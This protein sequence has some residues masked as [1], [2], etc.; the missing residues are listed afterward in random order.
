MEKVLGFFLDLVG[1]IIIIYLV[2]TIFFNR[3][4]KVYKSLKKNYEIKLF[5]AKYDL[6]MRKT[7][8]KKV[9]RAVTIINSFILAFT[10]SLVIRING[11]MMSLIVGFVT[12]MI[13]IYSLYEITGNYFK[14][15]E[16]DKNV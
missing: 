9:L 6:Y 11:F 2:Y 16:D 4:R 10:T 12:I 1:I 5:I 3:K 14:R 8:Y 15:K 13:L 7:E